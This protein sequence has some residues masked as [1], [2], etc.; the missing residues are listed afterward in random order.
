MTGRA[1][2][3]N[4]ATQAL[5]MLP[6]PVIDADAMS[7]YDRTAE[8]LTSPSHEIADVAALVRYGRAQG[9][10]TTAQI[11]GVSCSVA[12]IT[13]TG[14]LAGDLRDRLCREVM[15]SARAHI[16]AIG[17]HCNDASDLGLSIE[18]AHMLRVGDIT[19]F[20]GD[21]LPGELYHLTRGAIAVLYALSPLCGQ[22]AESLQYDD[23]WLLQHACGYSA[24]LA[25]LAEE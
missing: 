15:V 7:I 10:I 4:C 23:F 2:T 16:A 11:G 6:I 22:A 3:L 18:H 21:E 12:G 14:S 20:C 8:N 1:Y 9:Q 25:H 5:A 17:L 19:P 13:H 24:V